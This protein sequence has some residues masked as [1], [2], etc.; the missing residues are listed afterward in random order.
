MIV[1]ASEAE[2]CLPETA[3]ISTA[4]SSDFNLTT[5]Q[6][7]GIY[8]G[9]VGVTTTL[10]LSRA[11]LC[12]LLCFAATSNLHSKMFKSLLR[13]PILFFDTNPVGEY[14][15]MCEVYSYYVAVMCNLHQTAKLEKSRAETNTTNT[16]VLV[17]IT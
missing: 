7:V 17:K 2:S 9:L 6:R 8:G 11:V 16:R 5:D 15:I 4:S 10:I 13:A 3:N 14:R 1:R 12:Y